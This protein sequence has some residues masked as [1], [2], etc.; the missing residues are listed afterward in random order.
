[1][2]RRH[3]RNRVVPGRCGG[4]A[5]AFDHVTALVMSPLNVR[6]GENW[7]MLSGR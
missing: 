6:S 2:K 7:M 3:Q 1:V 4:A 5:Q